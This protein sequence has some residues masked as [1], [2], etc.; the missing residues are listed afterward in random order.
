MF[1]T[2]FEVVLIFPGTIPHLLACTLDVLSLTRGELDLSIFSKITIYL[3]EK[4][5]LELCLILTLRVHE[6]RI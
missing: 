1:I 3:I 2:G 5:P 6:F 4:V